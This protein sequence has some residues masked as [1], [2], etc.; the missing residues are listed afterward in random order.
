MEEKGVD[1]DLTLQI[2]ENYNRGKYDKIEPIQAKRLPTM[3][4]GGVLDVTGGITWSGPEEEVR[5]RMDE[6]IP[7][8]DPAE[9]G[10]VEEGRP[11]RIVFDRPG[12]AALGFRLLPLVA[13]GVLNGGSATSYVDGKKNSSYSTTLMEAAR[14]EFDRIAEIAGSRPKGVTP[15]YVNPDGSPGASFLELKMR[16]LLIQELL[17]GRKTGNAGGAGGGTGDAGGANA[18]AGSK[19]AGVILF[20]MTNINNNEE[21]AEEYRDYQ[22]SPLLSELIRET[23][24]DITRVETG[25]QPMI[26]A[27]TH[28]DEG[29]PKGLFTEAFGEEG[30]ILPLPGGHGQNFQVL[31]DVYTRLKNRG[32]RFAYLGN[33]DNLG[34]TVDPVTL[35]LLALS[36]KQA[37]F[38]FSFKTPIDVKGGILV[39]DENDHL[40]CADIGPAVSEEDVRRHEEAGKPILF[41]CATGLFDLEYLVKSLE[42]IIDELPVRFS[43]Q[44]KDAG[45]YS[46][47]EQVTWEVLGLMDDFYV[48]GVEKSKRF[49]AAKLLLESLVT[50]GVG[51]DELEPGK[52]DVSEEFLDVASRLNQGLEEKLVTV[53]GMKLEEGVWKP[54]SVDELLSDAEQGR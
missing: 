44:N 51:L 27:Y 35:A 11:K 15:G 32:K 37:G 1:V 25:I 5:R 40:N 45:K 10:T 20:Q 36:G 8:L 53:Y 2:L 42:R 13:Y 14:E 18:R 39:I 9:F 54:K 22:V 16:S 46:Q 23:G 26:A 17:Y 21:I 41:N 31:R 6:L 50:S 24:N 7:G 19:G 48:F 43:D 28:S 38:E 12:L 49:L 34:N 4:T 3:E 52:G 33:V 30:R 47:A 29:R